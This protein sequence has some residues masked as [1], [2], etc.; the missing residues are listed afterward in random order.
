[1][2][3]TV[4]LATGGRSL[5]D[6]AGL[7]RRMPWTFAAF[8]LA[9]LAMIGIPPTGGFF[10][11]WY[12]MVGGLEAGADGLVVVLVGSGLLTAGYLFRLLERVWARPAP[13]MAMRPVGAEAIVPIVVLGVAVVVFGLLN[14]WIVTR[15]IVPSLPGGVGGGVG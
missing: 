4:Q 9:A 13:E 10:S 1:V 6:Y 7:G 14:T 15:V 11:K 12:L 8:T 5:D 3:G 2:T